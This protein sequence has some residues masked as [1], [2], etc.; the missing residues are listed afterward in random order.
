MKS[1]SGEFLSQKKFY[2]YKNRKL[3]NIWDQQKEL[4]F[5]FETIFIYQCFLNK[6]MLYNNFKVNSFVPII[7][8]TYR[9]PRRKHY[10]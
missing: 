5:D 10:G 7:K 3:M 2:S 4:F 1:F 9:N 8:I 6:K